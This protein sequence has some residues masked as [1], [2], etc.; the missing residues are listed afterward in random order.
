VN[1]AEDK[2]TPAQARDLARVLLAA[3]DL[4]DGS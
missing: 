4:L 1:L 3:A 2:L